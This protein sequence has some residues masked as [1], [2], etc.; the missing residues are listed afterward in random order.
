M[1]IEEI[2]RTCFSECGIRGGNYGFLFGKLYGQGL[3][4]MRKSQLPAYKRNGLQGRKV[5]FLQGNMR[6]YCIWSAGHIMRALRNGK[7]K[8]NAF[9]L[10]VSKLRP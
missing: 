2:C 8:Q 4:E 3:P 7:Q 1:I 5:R 9:L 10:G 6:I